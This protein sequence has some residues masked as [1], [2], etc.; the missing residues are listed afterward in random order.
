MRSQKSAI[1]LVEY[2]IKRG[3]LVRPEQCEIC[4]SKP[5]DY[6]SHA[7]VAHHWKGYDFPLSIWWVCRSCN[8]ILDVHDGS[9][10]M[11][12]AKKYVRRRQMQKLGYYA[13]SDLP[14]VERAAR[15]TL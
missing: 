14:Q 3:E 2:A 10:N 9:L 11:E 13:E 1:K 6:Q 8:G 4:T 15:V 12:Q 5:I 7:I